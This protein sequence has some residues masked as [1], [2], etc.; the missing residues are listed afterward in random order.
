MKAMEGVAHTSTGLEFPLCT[1]NHK[2]TWGCVFPI[3]LPGLPL[4]AGRSQTLL[5]I[6]R[7]PASKG[8]HTVTGFPAMEPAIKEPTG[9]PAPGDGGGPWPCFTQVFRALYLVSRVM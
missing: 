2:V 8:P 4:A 1:Q 6:G 5:C 7:N 9:C 3:P